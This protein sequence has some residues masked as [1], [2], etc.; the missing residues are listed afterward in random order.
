MRKCVCESRCV[1]ALGCVEGE[2]SIRCLSQ[3]HFTVL[4]LRPGIYYISQTSRLASSQDLPI[5]L[6]LGSQ[7][8]AKL[9]QNLYLGPG[10][11]NSGLHARVVSTYWASHSFHPL[12][13][14]LAFDTPRLKDMPCTGW[15]GVRGEFITDQKNEQNILISAWF[16]IAL[17]KRTCIKMLRH[18]QR[19]HTHKMRKWWCE[20]LSWLG[21]PWKKNI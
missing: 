9:C 10:V 18:I 5:P 19:K 1:G 20:V 4:F 6:E 17:E 7:S 8:C 16:N 11:W 14:F 3:S 12:Q 21:W 15:G 2:S 13:I